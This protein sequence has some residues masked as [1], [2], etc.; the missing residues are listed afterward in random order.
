MSNSEQSYQLILE[1]LRLITGKDNFYFKPIKPKMSDIEVVSLIIWA[2]FKSIDSEYQLFRE[3]K[4]WE[5]E[6]KIERSVYNRRKRNHLW[7]KLDKEW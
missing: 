4:G 5:I 2:E 3:I 7:K 1:Q 6:G